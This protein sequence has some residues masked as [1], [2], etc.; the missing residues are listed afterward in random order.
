MLDPDLLT[1]S[2]ADLATYTGFQ[3]GSTPTRELGKDEFLKML[4]TQL[5]H[6]DP[7]DPMKDQDFIAQLA[8][9]SS[10]EQMTNMN[11]NLTENLNWNYLLSQTINNTMATSLL[12]REVKALGNEVY[13]PADGETEL[14]YKLGA[15]AETVT[16]EIFDGSGAKVASYTVGKVGEGDQL[17][18]WDGR[19]M[20]GERAQPG[21]YS[22]RVTAVDVN[23]ADITVM[24]Y[25]LGIVEGV[26]YLEGQAY[27]IIDGAKISLG[28][29][30]EVGTGDD[31]G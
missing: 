13:L 25:T 31:N 27:L 30:I 18:E 26:Q 29:V 24:P 5:R 21:T 19:T 1:Q 17:F 8:Q 23:G 28:D 7:M 20:H 9:F 16:I 2:V 4:I 11:D 10:L 15:Y 6:Q 22:F 14:H 3:Q 12:G